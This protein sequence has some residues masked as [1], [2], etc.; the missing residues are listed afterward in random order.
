M[1]EVAGFCIVLG[2][3]PV[4]VESCGIIS[5]A[6]LGMFTENRPSSPRSLTSREADLANVRLPSAVEAG[7]AKF[8][9]YVQPPMDSKIFNWRCFFLSR[10]S[11]LIQP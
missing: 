2:I 1:D 11:C 9:E 5:C 10:K 6:I 3:F 8:E 4:D 7:R